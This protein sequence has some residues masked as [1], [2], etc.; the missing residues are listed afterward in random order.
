MI[1][2]GVQILGL[3][4]GLAAFWCVPLEAGTREININT[5]RDKIKGGWVGHMAGVSWGA[6]T[7]FQY[8]GTIIPDGSVPNWSPSL[9][10]DSYDQD[11]LYVEMPFLSAMVEH[12]ANC[13][14]TKFGD[15][16][17]SFTPGLAHANMIGRQNLQA[18][19]QVPDSGYYSH[20]AHCDDIDWQI[21][22]NFGG[23]IAPGQPNAAAELT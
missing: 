15:Y 12:G 20:N 9:V 1:G 5:L 13:D 22:S 3:A 10:N 6:P 7:E 21:E 4:A 19:W 18:G 23:I 11:D 17:R 16:F 8:Q 14:W 2:R